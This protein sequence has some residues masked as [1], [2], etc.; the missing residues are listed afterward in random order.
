MYPL[1]INLCLINIAHWLNG[2]AVIVW[3][4]EECLQEGVIDI[5]EGCG[6]FH[7]FSFWTVS[8]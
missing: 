2:D 8:D 5:D 6:Q 4:K 3:H 1:I 7:S